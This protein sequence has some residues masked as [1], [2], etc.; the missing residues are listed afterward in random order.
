MDRNRYTEVPINQVAGHSC[1]LPQHTK[2]PFSFM[3]FIFIYNINR[4]R[5]ITRLW[6]KLPTGNRTDKGEKKC[7]EY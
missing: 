7:P 4:K 3:C 6:G 1:T 5:R 2:F